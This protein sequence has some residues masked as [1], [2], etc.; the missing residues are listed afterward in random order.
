[1]WRARVVA[2]AVIA[3]LAVVGAGFLISACYLA[4]VE[5]RLS[6]SMSALLVGLALMGIAGMVTLLAALLNRPAAAAASVGPAI[7][8]TPQQCLAADLESPE[9]LAQQIGTVLRNLN[10]ATIALLGAG[11]LMGM[12]RR[13]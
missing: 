4:L 9:I 2:G 1:M 13:R 6:P 11:L 3:A 8:A 12:L 7:G 10:P 5:L